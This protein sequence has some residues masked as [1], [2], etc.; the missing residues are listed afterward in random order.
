MGFREIFVSAALSASASRQATRGHKGDAVK[1]P[2]LRE[3]FVQAALKLRAEYQEACIEPHPAGRGSEREATLTTFLE[4]RLPRRFGLAK[5]HSIDIQDRCSPQLDVMIYDATYGVVYR[6]TSGGTFIPHDSLAAT[7]EVKSSLTRNGIR[8]AF[9]AAARTKELGRS[10]LKIGEKLY[11]PRSVPPTFLFAF[12]S[13]LSKDQILDAYVQEFF[14]APIGCH[15]D[16]IFVLDQC[17]VALN[18]VQPGRTP[19]DD[20]VPMHLFL[21]RSVEGGQTDAFFLRPGATRLSRPVAFEVAPGLIRVEAWNTG[22]L[23]LWAFL[24]LLTIAL[25]PSPVFGGWVPW[26]AESA[27]EWAVQNIAVCI[28]GTTPANLR[29][30]EIDRVIEACGGPTGGM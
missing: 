26:N 21:G 27:M 16:C 7:I 11:G 2:S 6:P 4:M 28:S 13:E 9:R 14:S 12:S 1:T 22:E 10:L 18:L 24:R 19:G 3:I 5:G 15:L 29:Q 25:Q 23:T 30:A 20:P 17:E 8:D